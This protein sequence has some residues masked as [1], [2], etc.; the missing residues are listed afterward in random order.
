MVPEPRLE[1]LPPKEAIQALEA[2]G[3]RLHETFSYKDAWGDEHGGIFTVAKSTGFDILGDV[4]SSLRDALAEG[5]TFDQ[6]KKDITPVLQEKGWWG[7]QEILDPVTGQLV[8]A[9]LGSPR[10]LRTIYDTNMRVSRAAGHWAVID[11]TKARRPWLR[12][13]AVQDDRTRADHKHWHGTVLSVDDPWWDS[14][15]PPNGWHCRCTVQQLNDRDL[16]RYGH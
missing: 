12:Y 4:H 10:R 2:R 5:G 9:Q 16:K 6:W 14:H 7:K 1:P 15:A 13:V 8:E 3:R 11:R